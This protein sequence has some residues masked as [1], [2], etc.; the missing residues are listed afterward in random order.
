MHKLYKVLARGAYEFLE[1]TGRQIIECL[2]KLD[3]RDDFRTKFGEA[4]KILE[5]NPDKVFDLSKSGKVALDQQR[6]VFSA[7]NSFVRGRED[8]FKDLKQ[9]KVNDFY[10]RMDLDR[11]G[12][13]E[14]YRLDGRY[15]L[16]RGIMNFEGD[17]YRVTAD[18]TEVKINPRGGITK[19]EGLQIG[20]ISHGKAEAEDAF[21]VPTVKLSMF[22]V[23]ADG[24]MSLEGVREILKTFSMATDDS[25]DPETRKAAMARGEFYLHLLENDEAL[26]AGFVK[27]MTDLIH[28]YIRETHDVDV[29]NRI[30][31]GIRGEAGV[32]S[33]D[34][35][36]GKIIN[37]VS[38]WAASFK[39]TGDAT[40]Q[41][42]AEESTTVNKF[43]G[44]IE[45]IISE[46]NSVLSDK[47]QMKLLGSMYDNAVGKAL[48][49]VREKEGEYET[50]RSLGRVLT[51]S[52]PGVDVGRTG[53]RLAHAVWDQPPLE[54]RARQAEEFVKLKYATSGLVKPEDV[55]PELKKKENN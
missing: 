21:N 27:S 42:K 6:T 11:D 33:D 51:G 17:I 39:F 37:L 12:K 9:G 53:E 40:L 22:S 28:T 35:V 29:A 25:L 19:I 8:V 34:S 32:K 4:V 24:R 49:T 46:A 44:A 10:V 36:V 1:L 52:V 47:E 41:K 54:E 13:R 23:G 45:G 43:A 3:V 20:G 5:S 26:R 14:L 7:L 55:F 18:G 2:R 30:A 15:T 48:N 31:V 50:D 38:G 16:D